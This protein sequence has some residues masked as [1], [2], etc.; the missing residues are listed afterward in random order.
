MAADRS[1]AG[2]FSGFWPARD[3]LHIARE[4]AIA[5]AI[6]TVQ[7]YWRHSGAPDGQS[8]PS[9]SAESAALRSAGG[10]LA[11]RFWLRSARAQKGAPE[12]GRSIG[13]RTCPSFGQMIPFVGDIFHPRVFCRRS[14]VVGRR[15]RHS[16][17]P[18][19]SAPSR[20]LG[21]RR[22]QIGRPARGRPM[23]SRPL[24]TTVG[25]RRWRYFSAPD[26]LV[27]VSISR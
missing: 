10:R 6:A 3:D 2:R 5:I 11:F 26:A 20:A 14:P 12:E 16:L 8:E 13:A 25:G 22:M 4:R 27:C 18:S 7:P 19:K 24:A 23:M 17:E 9:R 21:G 15:S 1:L